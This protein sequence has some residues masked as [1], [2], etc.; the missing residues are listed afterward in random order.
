MPRFAADENFKETILCGLRQR[1]PDLDA[2]RVEHVGL[3]G[4]EDPTILAWSAEAGRVLLTH[5]QDTMIGYAYERLVKGFLLPG[6]VLVPWELAVGR[7][8]EDLLVLIECN[9]EDEWEGQ[10]KYLP[11]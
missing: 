1:I 2:V 7:A 4:A 8:I 10:V 11:L 3:L 5:D 6:I 9:G